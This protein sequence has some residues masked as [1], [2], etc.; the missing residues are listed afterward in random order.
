MIDP[1]IKTFKSWNLCDLDALLKPLCSPIAAL[2]LGCKFIVG[3]TK[4]SKPN[5]YRHQNI[6]RVEG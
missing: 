6:A 5:T 4:G 3:F 1:V 2:I